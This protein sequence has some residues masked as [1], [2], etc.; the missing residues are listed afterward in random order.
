MSADSGLIGREV[1]LHEKRLA[2]QTEKGALTEI[3]Q[4]SDVS[5]SYPTVRSGLSNILCIVL[6]RT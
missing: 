3:G 6:R 5:T 2:V 1:A 4:A